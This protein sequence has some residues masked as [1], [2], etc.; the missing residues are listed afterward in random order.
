MGVARVSTRRRFSA[1]SMGSGGD[2]GGV[3]GSSFSARPAA[4][5]CQETK[6]AN[7]FRAIAPYIVAIVAIFI[8]FFLGRLSS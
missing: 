8:T 2:E 1:A 5:E 4:A 7:N 3:L 6:A